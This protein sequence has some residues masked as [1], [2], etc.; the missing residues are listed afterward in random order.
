MAGGGNAPAA[1]PAPFRAS[2]TPSVWRVIRVLSRNALR[3]DF[4]SVRQGLTVRDPT[5]MEPQWNADRQ[6]NARNRF[7]CEILRCKNHQIRPPPI[8]IVS[9]GQEIAFVFVGAER[10]GAITASPAAPCSKWCSS[11]APFDVMFEQGIARRV[12]APG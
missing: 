11:T 9:I 2:A 4:R 6:K 7:A 8:E 5:A 3:D 10:H 1:K 12:A